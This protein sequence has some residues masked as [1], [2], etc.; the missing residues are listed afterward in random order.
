MKSSPSITF[1]PF[2]PARPM[3]FPL[4]AMYRKPAEHNPVYISATAATA[5]GQ[6]NDKYISA[7]SNGALVSDSMLRHS[8]R[9]YFE[10]EDDTFFV[11]SASFGSFSLS[12][13]EEPRP[14]SEL[15]ELQNV[16]LDNK[17]SAAMF[18][19]ACKDNNVETLEDVKHLAETLSASV[20]ALE[21]QYGAEVVARYIDAGLTNI[22]AFSSYLDDDLDAELALS[23]EQSV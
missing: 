7:Q 23:I 4:P 5:L 21:R 6:K 2:D 19:N 14:Y 17:F 1:R 13:M 12:M 3:R 11:Y 20:T 10:G 9:L 15:M 22:A 8:Y 18:E 16:L